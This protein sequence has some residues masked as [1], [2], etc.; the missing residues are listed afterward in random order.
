MLQRLEFNKTG[1]YEA[2]PYLSKCMGELSF[3]R[4]D[5]RPY[6][7]TKLDKSGGNW[8]VNNSNR[9]V[10]FEP[11]KLCMF[12]NGR[13]YHPAPFDDFGLVRS[14][15]AEELFH[16]FEFDGDGKPFAFNWEDRQISLTNQLLAFSNN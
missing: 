14:S 10:L 9:K 4:C 2:F 12:P 3:L 8:I 5:D 11:D 6:V 16:R 15:I 7:F 1:S 13:L